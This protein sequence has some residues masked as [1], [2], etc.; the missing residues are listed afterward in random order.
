MNMPPPMSL[1]TY[2]NINVMLHECYSEIT[3]N[4]MKM[5]ADETIT[6]VGQQ[7][8]DGVTNCQ[9]SVDSTWQKHGH[10]SMNGIVTLISKENGECLDM[11][12]FPKN[13][14]DV[15]CGKIKRTMLVIM[16]G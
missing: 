14:E 6:K 4:S 15:L 12:C 2:D 3:Q 16:T 11:V 13:A 1:P 8:H 7:E 5:G 9:V 10:A